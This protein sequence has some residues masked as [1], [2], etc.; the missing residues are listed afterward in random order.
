[1]NM[2]KS[3]IYAKFDISKNLLVMSQQ[4]RENE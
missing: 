3:I 2:Y 1:M 4:F